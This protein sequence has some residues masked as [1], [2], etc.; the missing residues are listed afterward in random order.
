MVY[1]PPRHYKNWFINA[2][3]EL[4]WWMPELVSN[5]IKT[6]LRT[7][8]FSKSVKMHAGQSTSDDFIKPKH[9]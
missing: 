5:K 7:T 6:G 1:Y 3:D 8:Y 2:M 4:P 9:G